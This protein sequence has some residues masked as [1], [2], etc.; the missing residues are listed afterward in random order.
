FVQCTESAWKNDKRDRVFYEHHFPHEKISETQKFVRKDIRPL[1]Q[2]Q[3]DIQT[4]GCGAAF[5]RAFVRSLHDT[6]TSAGDYGVS[7]LPEQ[8]RYLLSALICDAAG[9]RTR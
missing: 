5:G 9:K 7:V 4:D 2:R 3:L 1:F 6:G 8:A